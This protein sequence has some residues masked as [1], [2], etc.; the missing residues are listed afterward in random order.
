MTNAA[1]VPIDFLHLGMGLMGI[2]YQK[3]NQSRNELRFV[4]LFGTKPNICSIVWNMLQKKYNKNVNN[5]KA[6]HLLWTFRFMKSYGSWEVQAAELKKD[7]K[8]VR[9]WVWFYIRGIAML[10]P[11]VVSHTTSFNLSYI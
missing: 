6:V 2:K 11:K 7:S 8:T 5:P 1:L 4:A 3:S 10:I 9:K